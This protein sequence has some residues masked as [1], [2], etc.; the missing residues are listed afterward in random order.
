MNADTKKLELIGIP[1]NVSPAPESVL[2]WLNV[3]VRPQNLAP[4]LDAPAMLLASH[5][6]SFAVAMGIVTVKTQRQFIL[7]A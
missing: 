2:K 7:L 5:A 4:M 6:L 1:I 3:V